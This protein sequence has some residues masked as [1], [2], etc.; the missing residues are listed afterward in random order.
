M[1][2]YFYFCGIFAF[3]YQIESHSVKYFRNHVDVKFETT[4]VKFLLLRSKQTAAEIG[5]GARELVSKCQVYIHTQTYKK[6]NDDILCR[7][8]FPRNEF[9][10]LRVISNTTGD[11]KKK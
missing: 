7:I 9:T 2:S 5:R 8:N 6:N 3:E 1:T 4:D 10:K 11:L